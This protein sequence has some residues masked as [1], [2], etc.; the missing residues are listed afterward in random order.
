MKIAIL[1]TDT[2]RPEL[3]A[4]YGQY[5]QMFITLLQQIEPGL[6]FVIYDVERQQYPGAINTL[7]QFD[8]WLITGSKSSVYDDKPWIRKLEG[9]IRLLHR[10]QR[11]L[12]GICFGHQLVAQALGGKTEKSAAGWG[13]GV[14]AVR[15]THSPGW[16]GGHRD[17]FKLLVSH[18]DQVIEPAAGSVVL[19]GSPFCPNAV[20]QVGQHILTFQ[21]HPEFVKDYARRLINFRRDLLGE[22]V[23]RQG[24]ASL[25]ED[26][27]QL[28][29]ARWIIGFIRRGRC[30]S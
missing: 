10:Q 5:P 24:M 7:S 6:E 26:T 19:A 15:W 3:A 28:E 22:D 1:K 11:I 14:H 2:I 9:F 30:R 25:T 4:G 20:C 18:Q 29:V 21:G 16:P 27:D 12:I 17:G 23:Y 8:G 13:V